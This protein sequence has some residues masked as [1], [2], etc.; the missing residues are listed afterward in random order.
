MRNCRTNPLVRGEELFD[1]RQ[2]AFIQP[3]QRDLHQL[4]LSRTPAESL[5]SLLGCHPRIAPSDSESVVRAQSDT[6][7]RRLFSTAEK[8]PCQSSFT[9]SLMAFMFNIAS[10]TA[11]AISLLRSRKERA[12]IA[13]TLT[14]ICGAASGGAAW[15]VPP[16]PGCAPPAH[17]RR[18]GS[19]VDPRHPRLVV[20]QSAYS[21]SASPPP[22]NSIDAGSAYFTSGADAGSSPPPNR[23]EQPPISGA[24]PKPLFITVDAT[25]ESVSPRHLTMPLSRARLFGAGVGRRRWRLARFG[26]RPRRRRA[27]PAWRSVLH[28]PGQYVLSQ[29]SHCHSRSSESADA[30]CP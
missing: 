1:R 4:N 9:T 10:R 2:F 21:R 24:S 26:G 8:S 29:R 22:E 25:D 28:L 15:R 7:R 27:P 12:S 16:R 17:R 5:I 3:A 19:P 13:C 14:V 6:A 18:A 23:L 30:C 11:K 20:V